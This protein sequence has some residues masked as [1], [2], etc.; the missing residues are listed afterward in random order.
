[1]IP[2]HS[3]GSG[4]RGLCEYLLGPGKDNQPE[5]ASIIGGNMASSDAR[6]LASEFGAIDRGNAK[7]P[8]LHISLSAAQGEHLSGEKWGAVAHDYMR[9]LGIEPDNYQHAIVHHSDRDHDHIHIVINRR[10]LDGTLARE[11]KN[12]WEIGRKA[13][14]EIEKEHGL[15]PGEQ[16]PQTDLGLIAEIRQKTI[17]ARDQSRGQGFEAFKSRLA[18][19]GI[20]T[21]EY[22]HKESGKLNGL[23]FQ[24]AGHAAVKAGDLGEE[25]R[26]K[27]LMSE[28]SPT[29]TTKSRTTTIAGN[30][31]A[32]GKAISG[33]LSKMQ[34]IPKIPQLPKIPG[35]GGMSMQLGKGL[36]A[37]MQSALQSVQRQASRQKKRKDHE[38]E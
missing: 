27:N 5:R 14:R 25:F 37:G 34:G 35:M 13:A 33:A 23:A 3:K 36:A 29:S 30:G 1:M 32:A 18:A 2:K 11:Q 22:R 4:F 7:K 10:G 16:R 12:D 21:I 31:A 8:V 17:A 6:G 38:L 20:K 26:T 28:L 15:Q 9:K 24:K 19:D